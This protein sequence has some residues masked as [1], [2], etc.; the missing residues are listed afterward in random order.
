MQPLKTIAASVL[1][2]IA[3]LLIAGQ[4]RQQPL[5]LPF[6]LDLAARPPAFVELP[7]FSGAEP[8][9]RWT[10]GVE[11]KLVLPRRLP[12][13]LELELEARA[14]GPNVGQLVTIQ[15]GESTVQIAFSAELESRRVMLCGLRGA[16]ELR[17]RPA[18]PTS[19][20]SLGQSQDARQLGIGVAR[21]SLRALPLAVSELRR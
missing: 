9:G 4:R 6:E 19:P 8:W 12:A 11:A 5:E 20:R 7:G 18:R 16:R 3:A 17:L 10:D 15:G 13:C 14:F 1:P 2:V 21:I